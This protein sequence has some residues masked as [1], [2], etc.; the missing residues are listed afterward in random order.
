[1]CLYIEKEKK[2]YPRAEVLKTDLVA[3]KTL[4]PGGGGTATSI[5]RGYV[6]LLEK[7]VVVKNVGITYNQVCYQYPLGVQKKLYR[8]LGNRG[9]H[10]FT[11]LKEAKNDLDSFSQKVVYKCIIPKGSRLW[12][13]NGNEQMSNQIIVKG[14]YVKPRSKKPNTRTSKK[15]VVKRKV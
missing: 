12:V 8:Y 1:M 10:S 15:R 11:T 9:L 13:G 7:K 2:S 3:Y 6:Y 5:H 14:K 4:V